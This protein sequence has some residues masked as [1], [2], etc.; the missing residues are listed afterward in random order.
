[1][2]SL[3]LALVL[4]VVLTAR[5]FTD[6]SQVS[7][8]Q[9]LAL[10]MFL[11]FMGIVSVRAHRAVRGNVALRAADA[12]RLA[13]LLRSHEQ[14]GRAERLARLGSCDWDPVAGSLQWSDEH[15]RLWG[16][17]PQSAAPTAALFHAGV[18][19]VDISDRAVGI[20]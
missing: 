7:T 8:A 15:F 13:A 5:L 14:L 4:V 16:L 10:L 12:Q 2:L 19:G 3:A 11:V 6:G 9:G 18:E 20:D 1:A 17:E